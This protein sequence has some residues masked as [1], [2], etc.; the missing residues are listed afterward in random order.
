MV[1]YDTPSLPDG[2]RMHYTPSIFIIPVYVRYGTRSRQ[3][4]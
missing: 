2:I 3:E 1:T 4:R